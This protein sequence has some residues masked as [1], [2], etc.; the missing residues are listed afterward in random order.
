MGELK[1]GDTVRFI[2][3]GKLENF[4][5][6]RDDYFVAPNRP[7]IVSGMFKY[8]D[9]KTVTKI[10]EIIDYKTT[11]IVDADNGRW[12]WPNFCFER[13]DSKNLEIE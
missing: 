1:E 6:K 3:L 8:L 11:Y 9:G 4:A 12:R 2:N 10:L 5:Q 13:V 7:T